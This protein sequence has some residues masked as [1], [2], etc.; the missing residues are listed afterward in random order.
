MA[1]GV[2]VCQ[3]SPTRRSSDYTEFHIPMPCRM[4]DENNERKQ[5]TGKRL[6]KH[7]NKHENNDEN[8]S[9]RYSL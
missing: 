2:M 5:L 3:M 4:A 7:E 6:Q 8:D 9:K 1:H